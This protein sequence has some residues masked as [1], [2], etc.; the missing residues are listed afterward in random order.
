M[1]ANIILRTA[2]LSLARVMLLLV[3]CLLRAVT[4][5]TRNGATNS[6]SDAVRSPRSKIVQLATSL[7][8]LSLEVLPTTLL[9][10]VLQVKC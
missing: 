4:H 3:L 9:L 1:L 2:L 7:L 5:Q 8:L 10:E 6:A